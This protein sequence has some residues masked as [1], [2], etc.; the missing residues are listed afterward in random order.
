MPLDQLDDLVR[1]LQLNAIEH[2]TSKSY[3]TGARHYL[4]F[5]LSHNLPI[6][7]TPQTLARYIAFSSMS[8]ASAPKYLTGARHFLL[9]FF[10]N[11]DRSR[12]HPSVRATIR[13]AKKLRADPVRRKLPL[14]LAH[15]DCFFARSV[16]TGSY[17]DLLFITILSCCFYA[18]HRSGELIQKT[19]SGAL[20]WR[21]IIKRGSLT[22]EGGF[23][24]Y[25]LPYHKGDPFYRGT[26]I[27]FMPQPC[28]DPVKLLQLYTTRRDS[29]HGARSPLFIREDGRPPSR[30]WFENNLFTVLGREYGGHSARAGGATFYASL[31]LSS[32][33]I[34][35]IGRWT[36]SS[37]KIYIRD[38]PTIRAAQQLASLTSA[39]HPP[40]SS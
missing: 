16:K 6:D 8:I 21:K 26:D 32:D 30:S 20:D 39:Q 13:G 15:L 18:C 22:F 19:I 11:F 25:R 38:N 10:P 36:S 14:R 1:H 7:P 12:S 28:A 3:A 4:F 23:A 9:N 40:L 2:S 33:V 27:L 29:L 34:Q 31:G 17:D 24:Q 35:A 37:W 5:C